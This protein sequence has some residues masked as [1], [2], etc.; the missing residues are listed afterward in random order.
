MCEEEALYQLMI[1][2]L[3]LVSSQQACQYAKQGLNE[4]LT[5]FTN[6]NGGVV[7]FAYEVRNLLLF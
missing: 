1:P 3:D 6:A 4:T 5:F 2:D 7:S